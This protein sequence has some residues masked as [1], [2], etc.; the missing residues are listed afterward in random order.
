MRDK[1]IIGNK[2]L[3]DFDILT[4]CN[5]IDLE[6]L[7]DPIKKNNKKYRKYQSKLGRLD[8]KSESVKK[9]LPGVAVQLYNENNGIYVDMITSAL[10]HFRHV[11][12]EWVKKNDVDISQISS[13]SC[14]KLIDLIEHNKKGDFGNFDIRL[15]LLQLKMNSIEL[16]EDIKVQLIVKYSVDK[17][18]EKIERKNISK[19]ES[20]IKEVEK[21]KD[22][23]E[24]LIFN[25]NDY[26]KICKKNN[27]FEEEM[28]ILKVD[29]L[30]RENDYQIANEKIIRLNENAESNA[31]LIEQLKIENSSENSKLE[32]LINENNHN[33]LKIA[34]LLNQNSCSEKAISEI[35]AKNLELQDENTKMISK[36]KMI[37]ETNL[38]LSV[39]NDFESDNK[40]KDNYERNFGEISF[41]NKAIVED[42][43]ISNDECFDCFEEFMD[44]VEDNFSDAGIKD[45]NNI[46]Y[47]FFS[48]IEIG[49]IPLLVGFRSIDIAKVLIA[50]KFNESSTIISIPPGFNDI[51]SLK[52]TIDN[53]ET[54]TVIIADALGKMSD[55]LYLPLI[56]NCNDKIL[57]F[58]LEDQSSLKYIE[59][60][61]Y[62]YLNLIVIDEMCNCFKKCD[63]LSFGTYSFDGKISDCTENKIYHMKNKIYSYTRNS[64]INCM[65]KMLK[66][67]E[68]ENEMNENAICNLSLNLFKTEQKILFSRE[69][70]EKLVSEYE[71]NGFYNID[72]FRKELE[73]N[74]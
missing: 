70:C 69:E 27:K 51:I 57:V 73:K 59:S 41:S 19:N 33:K 20:L 63:K 30:K 58:T 64:L 21:L 66:L 8:K 45:K 6:K 46:I 37:N 28:D 3:T 10:L 38:K 11:F 53:T 54:K 12:D 65:N 14:E 36:L 48:S 40:K 39:L 67:N 31:I 72:K 44:L 71:L 62:N 50:S 16:D 49:L 61:F 32:E 24:K 25:I 35:K 26:K 74:E 56:R 18:I 68:V 60:Y 2:E 47:N 43:F 13:Y 52:K 42:G 29:C 55:E 34:K 23:N 4:L 22:D 5:N 9:R 15:F 1:Y 17:E 7:L